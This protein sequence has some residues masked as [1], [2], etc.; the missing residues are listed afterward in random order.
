MYKKKIA[1]VLKKAAVRIVAAA[2]FTVAWRALSAGSVPYNAPVV[3]S[4]ALCIAGAW[5][6]YLRLDGFAARY[7][8]HASSA[9]Q[10]P[11]K[12]DESIKHMLDLSPEEERL[13]SE[14]PE[15]AENA[16]LGLYANLLAG[17]ALIAVS[18]IFR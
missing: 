2:V 8:K 13:L 5:L 12:T 3:F 10:A 14:E 11:K 7:K 6:S 18:F 17:T 1:V 16:K 15:P 9:R 4:G